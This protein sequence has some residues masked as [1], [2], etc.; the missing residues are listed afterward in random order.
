MPTT[1]DEIRAAARA[2]LEEASA[3]ASK[4][5][6][7]NRALTP[8]ER[9]RAAELLEEVTKLRDKADHQSLVDVV[10]GMQAGLGTGPRRGFG[11]TLLEAGL[12]RKIDEPG[13]LSVKNGVSGA[14]VP[15]WPIFGPAGFK[16]PTVPATVDV[17]RSSPVGIEPLGRDERFMFGAM[18]RADLGT[19]LSI[20]DFRETVR[21]TT[22]TVERD[23]AAVTSKATLNVTVTAVNTA[24]KQ[25]AVIVDGIPNAIL[26]SLPSFRAYAD[27]NLRFRIAQALD[28]HVYTN[29]N[30]NATF[31]MTGT[32]MIEKLRNA[33]TAVQADGFSPD[34]AVLNPTDAAALDLSADAGG[35]VFP[36]RDTGASS[37]LW[38]LTVV[39]RVGA[40]T[41]PPLV[42]DTT[43]IGQLYL[44]AMKLDLDPF[45][46]VSGDNF[47]TNRT[48]I[49]AEVNTLMHVRSAKAA[50]R[51]AA[52]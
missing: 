37:P 2:K 49:R 1:V 12:L 39:V 9:R 46:G 17:A 41:E 16:A 6:G 31:G 3:I 19:D 22:G 50:R 5:A 8:T 47:E 36:V 45:A 7:E 18:P 51:I 13:T 11:D 27:A 43:R 21:T 30:A 28:A 34:L 48:D 4:A 20:Q 33:I 52:T 15:S 14:V 35:F 24:V 10:D 32:T 29:V 25:E 40:G 23:P 42:V 44:G 26:E 38:G